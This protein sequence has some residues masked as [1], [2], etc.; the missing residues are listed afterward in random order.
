MRK[1]EDLCI[2]QTVLLGDSTHGEIIA[3]YSDLYKEWSG[4]EQDFSYM[5]ESGMVRSA[6]LSEIMAIY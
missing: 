6:E 5:T 2:G 4:T 1:I 3:I